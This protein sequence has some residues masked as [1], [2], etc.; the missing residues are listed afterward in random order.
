MTS[1]PRPP[2]THQD[3]V[4]WL[5]TAVL[6]VHGKVTVDELPESLFDVAAECVQPPVTEQ[7]KFGVRD[8]LVNIAGAVVD[9]D[10]MI[11]DDNV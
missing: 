9:Q 5:K 1:I 7:Y 3:R 6:M 2:E 4:A 8:F 11:G 10:L